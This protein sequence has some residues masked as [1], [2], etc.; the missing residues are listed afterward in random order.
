MT[1]MY[2]R[3]RRE[4]SSSPTCFVPTWR[5]LQGFAVALPSTRYG[6]HSK[7]LDLIIF[8]R[9]VIAPS[10][11]R[12]T[13]GVIPVESI[14]ATVEVKSTLT[15]REL[16][17]AVDNAREGL[18]VF[19]TTASVSFAAQSGQS[20]RRMCREEEALFRRA[21]HWGVAAGR[22][23]RPCRGRVPPGRG[24]RANV[25]RWTSEN[26]PLIDRAKPAT[27]SVAS[28]TKHPGL[29]RGHSREH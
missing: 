24:L 10:M 21:N 23:G 18:R 22:G 9:R 19:Q 6:G 11:L 12:E 29:A 8:D 14:L 20:A 7:Q 13:D 2:L 3:G 4:K 5:P 27:T 15:R 16:V 1:T 28:E 17:G 25:P 26:R